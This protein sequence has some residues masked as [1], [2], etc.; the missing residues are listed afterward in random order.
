MADPT[1]EELQ[2]QV[3][4]LKS[5]ITTQYEPPTGTEYSYPVVNQPMNDEM[6]Q[7]VTLG[8]GSGVLDE[9]GRPYWLRGRENANN[10]LRITV[11][12]TTSNAQAVLRGFYHRMTADKTF[13]VPGVTSTTVFHF[14][15]TYDPTAST[16]PGGP[17]SLQMYAGTPPTTMGRFHI[18]LWKLTRKANQLLTEATV[19][20]VRTKVS[21]TITV[22]SRDQLPRPQ[23]QLWGTLAIVT[24]GVANHELLRAGGADESGGPSEWVSIDDVPWTDP[25]D[26][27]AYE[28]A[29]HG[30]PR[31]ARLTR[32]GYIEL[33]GHVAR[34]GGANF[35]IGDHGYQMYNL[36]DWPVGSNQQFVTCSTG[37]SPAALVKLEYSPTTKTVRAYPINRDCSWINLDGVRIYVGVN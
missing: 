29:G 17:I 14:C 18:V 2:Q 11:S 7:Y 35:T 27:D 34:V 10:T 23:E 3:D 22:D 9:G 33:R 8:L 37:Y 28:N 13:T 19:E 4:E 1:L 21:P 12:T 36:E 6:W 32:D 15:L 20:R 30:Y 25:G 31:G 16:A 26:T 24:T 5:L